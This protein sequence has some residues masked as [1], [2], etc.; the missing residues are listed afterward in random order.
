M[1]LFADS[2]SLHPSDKT[3]TPTRREIFCNSQEQE[4]FLPDNGPESSLLI[5]LNPG[6]TINSCK[7]F[8]TAPMASGLFIRLIK[9]DSLNESTRAFNSFSGNV[10]N[11]SEYCPISIVSIKWPHYSVVKA[12][13]G[14]QAF[15]TFYKLWFFTARTEKKL[16]LEHSRLQFT[17]EMV[18]QEMFPGIYWNRNC[19]LR[20]YAN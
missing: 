7:R 10:H 11:S 14:P 4:K 16:K 6:K 18:E 17:V 2:E 3:A 5:D 1:F 9:S 15:I 8:F 19:R 12:L 13:S 20:L